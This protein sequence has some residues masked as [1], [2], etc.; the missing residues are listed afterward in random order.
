MKNICRILVLIFVSLLHSCSRCDNTTIEL[1][2]EQKDFANFKTGSYWIMRD[3]VTGERDSLVASVYSDYDK[4]F[5]SK[6]CYDRVNKSIAY[7]DVYKLATHVK[8]TINLELELNADGY[9]GIVLLQDGFILSRNTF[10][11]VFDKSATINGT[12]REFLAY[13]AYDNMQGLSSQLTLSQNNKLVKLSVRILSRG[14]TKVW[15]LEKS[16]ILK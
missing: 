7:I 14:L 9:Q 16:L 10:K 15:E 13:S 1:S 2:Q 5:T 6:K 12:F 8:D 3:S 11:L 4:S